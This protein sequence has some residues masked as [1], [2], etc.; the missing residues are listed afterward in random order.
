MKKLVIICLVLLNSVVYAGL[1]T[2][3]AGV[4][5]LIETRNGRTACWGVVVQLDKFT[6]EE[7]IGPNELSLV[8]AKYNRELKELMTWTVDKS[9][10][11]LTVKF[12]SGMGDFGSGNAVTLV[13][14]PGVF[15]ADENQGFS[16]SLPTD[17]L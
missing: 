2:H 4:F 5:Q 10:K 11:M 17:P 16:I 13:L 8:D 3:T 7:T 1:K 9:K 15:P 12:K 14:K 6:F